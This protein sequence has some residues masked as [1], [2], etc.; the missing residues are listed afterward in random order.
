MF[1]VGQSLLRIITSYYDM[2]FISSEKNQFIKVPLRLR[3]AGRVWCGGARERLT[4]QR[5]T[6]E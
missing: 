5:F 3:K 4:K 2:S 6:Q 1:F